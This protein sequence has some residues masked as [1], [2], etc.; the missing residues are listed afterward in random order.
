[1][2]RVQNREQIVAALKEFSSPGATVDSARNEVRVTIASSALLKFADYLRSRF[3]GRPE[4]IAAEDTRAR[5]GSFM[6]RYIFELPGLDTF[7]IASMPLDE[8]QRSFPS[9]ATRWFL[10]SLFE[11]ELH[12][13]FGLLLSD[14]PVLGR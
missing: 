3:D 9:L 4:L 5:T 13:L 10:A 2:V 14:I 6:L 7:V 8:G 11:R 12:D 1:V